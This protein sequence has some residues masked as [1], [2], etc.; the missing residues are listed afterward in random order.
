MNVVLKAT[1]AGLT[2]VVDRADS[3]VGFDFADLIKGFAAK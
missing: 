1:R 2:F 3:E